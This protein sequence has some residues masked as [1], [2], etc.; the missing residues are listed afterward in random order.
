MAIDFSCPSCKKQFRVKDELGGKVAK[1][2]ACETK[3]QIPTLNAKQ[4]SPRT[5]S[6]LE[7]ILDDFGQPDESEDDERDPE[8]EA[9]MEEEAM[10]ESVKDPRCPSCGRKYIATTV[11]CVNCG[12]DTKTG[13]RM[14]GVTTRKASKPVDQAA[15]IRGIMLSLIGVLVGAVIWIGI[16][17]VIKRQSGIIAWA[18]GGLSGFGMSIAAKGGNR[19]IPGICAALM[20]LVGILVVKVVV[21]FFV[22][23]PTVVDFSDQINTENI[24]R[25]TLIRAIADEALEKREIDDEQYEAE[26]DKVTQVVKDMTDKE[27]DEELRRFTGET[28]ELDEE[29]KQFKEMV[30]VVVPLFIFSSF[31]CFDFIAIPLSL[32]TAYKIGMGLDNN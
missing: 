28:A 17:V 5:P 6:A 15:L 32:F 31:S 4:T 22:T 23:Y 10:V 11:V 14:K 9:A 2:T 8:L 12:Y 27:V 13:E 20:S 21:F 19:N 3:I 7:D 16:A 25:G 18:M 30:F 1:C 26:Y 24:A 29:F